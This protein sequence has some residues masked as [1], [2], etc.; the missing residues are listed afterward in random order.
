MTEKLIEDINREIA[1][2]DIEKITT[3][4]QLN[5]NDS[6]DRDLI[7]GLILY[8]VDK[9]I[10]PASSFLATQSFTQSRQYDLKAF[11]DPTPSGLILTLL[12]KDGTILDYESKSFEKK[13][14]S[15]DY[16]VLKEKKRKNLF[17]V[18]RAESVCNVVDEMIHYY[19]NSNAE[20]ISI[21]EQINEKRI[22]SWLYKELLQDFL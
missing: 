12:K 7:S 22:P 10:Y 18:L 19:R 17:L 2:V 9:Y 15:F 1:Q 8:Y 20:Q 5:M 14:Q 21:L 16:Q 6:H 11:L 3:L 4:E 13:L